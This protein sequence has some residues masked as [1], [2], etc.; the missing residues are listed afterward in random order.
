MGHK[1]I[2]IYLT[3]NIL[4]AIMAPTEGQKKNMINNCLY[5]QNGFIIDLG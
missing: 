1:F 5:I 3:F 2:N 4:W